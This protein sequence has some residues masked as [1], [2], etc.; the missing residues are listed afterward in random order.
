MASTT[1]ESGMDGRPLG[2][3]FVEQGIILVIDEH[4]LSIWRRE[5]RRSRRVLTPTTTGE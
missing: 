2:E 5:R 3:S 4:I 1:I